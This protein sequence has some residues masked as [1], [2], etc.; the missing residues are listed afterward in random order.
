MNRSLSLVPFCAVSVIVG[1]L[2]PVQAGD[3]VARRVLERLKAGRAQAGVAELERRADLDR[4]ALERARRVAAL[5]HSKRLSLDESIRIGLVQEEVTAYR[6]AS[7]HLDMVRGYTDPA[8][9]FLR[10]W[11]AYESAWAKAM[12]PG[13]DSVGI[14]THRADD[15]WVILVAVF[16]DEIRLPT[17]L[18]ELER[19]T[20]RAINRI[21]VEQGMLVLGESTVLTEI[22]RAHSEDMAR[23]RYFDHAS[24][25]GRTAKQR[26]TARGLTYSTVGEN[27]QKNHGYDDPVATAVASWMD[28]KAHRK[29]ILTAA[30]R[31]T[32]LGVAM[33]EDGTIYFTQLFFTP[34]DPSAE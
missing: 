8:S 24:P 14:A 18:R 12:K 28:S 34:R 27:I 13:L 21:R 1:A 25:D 10:A 17:N 5:P 19:D 16:L 7:V 31:E 22:A 26:V 11:T 9:G 20:I 6:S 15:G 29:N 32:G 33:T 4:V 3:D 23:R 30:F 2:V